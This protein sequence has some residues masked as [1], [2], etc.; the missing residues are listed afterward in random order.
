MQ[1]PNS[2]PPKPVAGNAHVYAINV[3]NSNS[4]NARIWGEVQIA[5]AM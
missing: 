4:R 2:T 5:W 1:L 3:D